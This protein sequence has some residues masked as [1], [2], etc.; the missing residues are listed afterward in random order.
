MHI[1][2]QH[3]K[4]AELGHLLH[5]FKG[6]HTEVSEIDAFH[7][8]AVAKLPDTA[9]PLDF[10]LVGHE[11]FGIRAHQHTADIHLPDKLGV[12][13]ALVE[14]VHIIVFNAAIDHVHLFQVVSLQHTSPIPDLQLEQIRYNYTDTHWL[15]NHWLHLQSELFQSSHHL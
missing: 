12:A 14:C 5:K 3:Q 6:L 4:E 1:A 15:S 2:I 10:M 9:D 11:E 8:V 7:F 13:V